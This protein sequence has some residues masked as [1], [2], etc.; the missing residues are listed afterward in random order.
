MTI[1]ENFK[2]QFN[3]FPRMSLIHPVDCQIDP[4]HRQMMD[5]PPE[6]GRSMVGVIRVHVVMYPEDPKP[7]WKVFQYTVWVNGES[8]NFEHQYEAFIAA[9]AQLHA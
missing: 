6:N 9:F 3:E 5:Y 4:S 2:G 7:E 1:H 8:K